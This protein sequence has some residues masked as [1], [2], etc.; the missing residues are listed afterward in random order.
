MERTLLVYGFLEAIIIMK[1]QHLFSSL[2]LMEDMILPVV[3]ITD[4]IGPHHPTQIL[5]NMYYT[6][7]SMPIV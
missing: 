3:G 6:L 1:T 5:H 2:S 7:E 4:T